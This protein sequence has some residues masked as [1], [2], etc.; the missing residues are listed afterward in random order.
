MSYN[1]NVQ[2]IPCPP[3][4]PDWSQRV[5][6][7][8]QDGVISACRMEFSPCDENKLAEINELLDNIDKPEYRWQVNVV[9]TEHGGGFSN[10]GD[11]TIICGVDGKPLQSVGGLPKCGAAHAR[12][13]AHAAL[14]VQYWQHRGNGFGT[15]SFIGIDRDA[16][17]RLGIVEKKL[18]SFD[19]NSEDLIVHDRMPNIDIPRDAIKSAQSKARCY[20]CRSAFYATG[21]SAAGSNGPHTG[22][23]GVLGTS[24]VGIS[25]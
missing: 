16:R 12:F 9:L 11:A 5:E 13:F 10:T 8:S 19:D 25:Y 15:V 4:I 3:D 24:R 6:R 23:G 1:L 2:I 14:V 22:V 7:P 20:H 17:H 21:S 18:W